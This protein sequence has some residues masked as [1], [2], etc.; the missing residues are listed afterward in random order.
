MRVFAGVE[1]ADA[2]EC[3][4][5]HVRMAGGASPGESRLRDAEEEVDELR[6][7]LRGVTAICIGVLIAGEC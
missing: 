6:V 2:L 1:F 3:V 7:C 5:E 4:H